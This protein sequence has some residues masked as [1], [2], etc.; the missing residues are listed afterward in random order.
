[1]I[2]EPGKAPKEDTILIKANQE[3]RYSD[4]MSVVNQLQ[5]DGYFKISLITEDVTAS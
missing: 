2:S 5:T 3:V 1:A 4:F